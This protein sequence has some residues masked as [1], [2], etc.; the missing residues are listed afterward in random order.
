MDLYNRN[1]TRGK[2]NRGRIHGLMIPGVLFI[3]GFILSNFITQYTTTAVTLQKFGRETPVMKLLLP[4]SPYTTILKNYQEY[5]I[6]TGIFLIMGP[7]LSGI[8]KNSVRK[9]MALRAGRPARA[10]I[11]SVTD[12]G[13]WV[14]NR[15]PVV[16][17]ELEVRPADGAPFIATVEESLHVLQ[18]PSIHPGAILNVVYDPRSHAVA[19]KG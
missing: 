15:H 12:T 19:I 7:I 14:N 9:G 16:E 13:M 6:I 5:L 17:L 18:I 11:L 1:S 10:E 2:W 4:L 3:M 8:I